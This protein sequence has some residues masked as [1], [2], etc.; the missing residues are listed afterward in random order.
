MAEQLLNDLDV[1]VGCNERRRRA[2]AQ[3]VQARARRA[4]HVAA[5]RANERSALRGS[6]GVPTW[7]GNTRSSWSSQGTQT[8]AASRSA[9]CCVLCWRSA[10]MT[11]AGSATNRRDR[12][13]FGSSNLSARSTRPSVHLTRTWPAAR[14]TSRQ[15]RASASPLRRPDPSNNTISGNSGSPTAASSSR[16]TSPAVR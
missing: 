3:R 14:S 15:C 12:S 16:L 2:M 6:M 8:G 5:I 7:V 4:R 13:V 10:S 11:G 1:H 9:A